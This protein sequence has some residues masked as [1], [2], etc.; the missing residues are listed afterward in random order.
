MKQYWAHKMLQKSIDHY[1]NKFIMPK[2][3]RLPSPVELGKAKYN[4]LP[5]K[6]FGNPNNEYSWGDYEF[7][8]KKDYP[9]KYWFYYT[10]NSW[11]NVK[12]KRPIIE[13]KYYIVS[14]SIRKYHLLDMRNKANKYN[15]GWIDADSQL[16]FASMAIMENFIIEQDTPNRLIDLKEE[17]LK[18]PD[19][20]EYNWDNG[21]K[22]CEDLLAMQ[23][24]WRIDHPRNI[25]LSFSG[26]EYGLDFDEKCRIEENEMMKKLIDIR[27]KMWT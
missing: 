20:K 2:F 15:Y 26:P 25:E 5:S 19:C 12:I 3:L 6:H 14:H 18:D 16:L 7:E 27:A 13:L 10:L 11:F 17:L 24:W 23:K 21:I 4:A 9:I 8:M 22:F 1:N